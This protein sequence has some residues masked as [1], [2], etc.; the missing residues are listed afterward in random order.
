[1]TNI[2]AVDL[3]LWQH[4]LKIDREN[5]F[6]NGKPSSKF[7][8][9]QAIEVLTWKSIQNIN[10]LEPSTVPSLATAKKSKG[11]SLYKVWQLSSKG[12]KRY[13]ACN[14]DQYFYL[15]LWPCDLKNNMCH[16]LARGIH[17][18]YRP[19]NWQEQNNMPP[20]FPK[21]AII[22]NK[23]IVWGVFLKKKK[24]LEPYKSANIHKRKSFWEITNSN[25]PCTIL[26]W[27]YQVPKIHEHNSTWPFS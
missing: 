2:S 7:S 4:D 8:N 5:L 25:N 19:T 6:P 13:C 20:F 10:P 12:A 18:I 9:N 1:M 27:K 11:H 26:N 14:K 15:A 22:R 24:S 16:L 3:D 21:G 23:Q 17:W